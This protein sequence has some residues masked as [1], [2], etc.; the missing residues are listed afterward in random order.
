MTNEFSNARGLP[1]IRGPRCSLQLLGG[2]RGNMFATRGEGVDAIVFIAGISNPCDSFVSS[3]VIE[4]L[5]RGGLSV[6]IGVE[7]I[8]RG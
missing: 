1:R 8:M 4:S 5:R 7:R 6:L 2:V 3:E